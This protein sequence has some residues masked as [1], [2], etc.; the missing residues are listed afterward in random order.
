MKTPDHPAMIAVEHQA[1]KALS[2]LPRGLQ[3][4][5]GRT[6]AQPEG[7]PPAPDIAALLRIM[8]VTGERALGAGDDPVARRASTRRGSLTASPRVPYPAEVRD[9]TVAGALGPLP[10]RLYIPPTATDGRLMVFYHGGGWVTGDLDTHDAPCR[11]IARQAATRVLAVDYRLAPEHPF[12]APVE[13]ALAAFADV[14]AR[15]AELGA[16]PARISVCGDSA[17]GNL[18]AVVSQQTAG[19]ARPAAALLIY[20]AC[21]FTGGTASRSLFAE[22]F[23]LEKSDMD[24]CQDRYLQAYGELTDPRVSPAFGAVDAEHPPTVVVTA[25]FDPL[26]DEGEAYAA[27][28]RAAGIPTVLRRYPGLIHGFMNLTAISPTSHDAMVDCCSALLAVQ[29]VGAGAAAPVSG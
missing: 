2:S 19:G 16:D 22:G 3:R 23:L 5:I 18:A 15:A 25:G 20:P 1:A 10:A 13:D 28:L 26:R 29:E 21:D 24:W 27:Q 8:Q 17:G 9:T 12:P 7:V 14:V 11:F 4:L 6:A